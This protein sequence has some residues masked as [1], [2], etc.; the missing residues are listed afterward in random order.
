[1]RIHDRL[2][3]DPHTPTRGTR[4]WAVAALVFAL[5]GYFAMGGRR[6]DALAPSWVIFS[7]FALAAACVLAWIALYRRAKAAGKVPQARPEPQRN[8]QPQR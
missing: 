3:D 2:Q 1:M 5:I 6:G 4:V 7:A 8:E